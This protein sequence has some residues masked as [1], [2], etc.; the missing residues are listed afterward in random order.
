MSREEA[1]VN[2]NVK[3]GLRQVRLY[4]A[5]PSDISLSVN[6]IKSNVFI[7]TIVIFFSVSPSRCLNK[8]LN[9]LQSGANFLISVGWVFPGFY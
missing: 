1:I 4:A 5:W 2:A 8:G 7:I 3:R 9:C 6:E